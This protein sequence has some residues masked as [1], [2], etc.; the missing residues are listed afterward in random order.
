MTVHVARVRASWDGQA[1]DVSAAT[2]PLDIKG[3]A[4]FDWASLVTWWAFATAA[5]A[6]V[7]TGVLL[8]LVVRRGR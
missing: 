7:L 3:V 4:L 8:V 2:R 5:V 1:W 6:A